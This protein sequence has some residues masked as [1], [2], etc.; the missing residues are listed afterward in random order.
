MNKEQL[1]LDYNATSPLAENVKTFL[2]KGD[3]LFANPSSVHS[4][5]KSSR[6]SINSTTQ[7]L[8]EFFNLPKFEIIYTSGATES[9]NM[10]THSMIDQF[11]ENFFYVCFN[12]DHAS[13]RNLLPYVF[14]R[15]AN[16]VEL[17][18]GK[19]GR[20]KIDELVKVV[21]AQDENKKILVNLT[22]VNSETGIVQDLD[23]VIDH[24][25]KFKNVFIHVDAV[26]SIGKIPEYKKLNDR[27]D[28]YSYSAHKFGAL[29]GVGFTFVKNS[30]MLSPLIIGG[31]QQESLR[32]GTENPLAVE[33]IKLALEEISNNL[34]LVQCLKNRNALEE[35]IEK[36]IGDEG[37]VVGKNFERAANTISLI[38]I[39]HKA[40]E[41]LIY[42]DLNKIAISAGSACSSGSLTKSPTIANMVTEELSDKAIRI[43][44]PLIYSDKEFVHIKDKFIKV[45]ESFY[46]S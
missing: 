33:S 31:G 1:Y 23:G 7:Y 32:S 22:W 43:S 41:V 44:L 27:V 28:F 8:K 12:S 34:N 21:Q 42:F 9:I 40:D 16:G 5:G 14:K 20:I 2:A 30:K 45:I 15:N 17:K 24:L 6:K 39:N 4:M 18:P 35:A 13:V 46:I 11:N 25:S 19:E 38:L 26:Q 37:F 10:I 36:A 3:L 29:K